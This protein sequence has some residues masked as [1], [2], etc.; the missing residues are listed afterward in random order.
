MTVYLARSEWTDTKSSSNGRWKSNVLGIAC[1][2]PA[3]PG[4]IGTNFKTVK[5][6]LN[7]WRRYHVFVRGWAD[8]GYNFAVDQAGRIWELRGLSNVGAH[9]ASE[10]NKDANTE[11]V[12]VLFVVGNDEIVSQAAVDA[13]RYLRQNIIK[14]RFPTAGLIKG[15]KE[16]RG[17]STACPGPHVLNKIHSDALSAAVATNPA[18]IVEEEEEMPTAD[19]LVTAFDRVRPYDVVM[20][21]QGERY[22]EAD[23]PNRRYFEIEGGKE[24]WRKRQNV[25]SASGHKVMVWPADAIDLPAFGQFAGSI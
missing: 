10:T 18:P 17:A 6:K 8:I 24:I 2:W 4:V 9:S 11:W 25:L 15:H 21:K 22:F 5:N 3:N 19:E 7:E 16:I 12:G 13:F 14:Q 20:F 1:H 23:V